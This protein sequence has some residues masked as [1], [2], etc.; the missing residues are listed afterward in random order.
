LFAAFLALGMTNS[1]AQQKVNTV[2]NI[3]STNKSAD[4]ELS[5][6]IKMKIS[7]TIDGYFIKNKDVKQIVIEIIGKASQVTPPAGFTNKDLAY[8]RAEEANDFIEAKYG[9]KVIISN[10]ETEIGKTKYVRGVDTK[11][12]EKFKQE[13]GVTV[14][15]KASFGPVLKGKFSS[16]TVIPEKNPDNLVIYNIKGDLVTSTGFFGSGTEYHPHYILS[17]TMSIVNNKYL[18]KYNKKFDGTLDE[19]KAL[20]TQPIS[21]NDTYYNNALKALIERYKN[22]KPIYL[23]DLLDKKTIDLTNEG[24]VKIKVITNDKDTGGSI[25]F[26]DLNNKTIKGVYNSNGFSF[27]SL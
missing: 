6:E 23:Y 12:D 14:N 2:T 7:K 13:Q 1:Q 8:K 24:T 21:K 18:E 27:Y 16:L 3:T 20:L 9:N 5:D 26:I 25:T 15:I 11:D 22:N 10:I 17:V 4:V 19:L